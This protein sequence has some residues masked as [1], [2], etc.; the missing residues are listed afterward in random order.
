[1]NRPDAH[2]HLLLIL[3]KQQ[4]LQ[5]RHLYPWILSQ[6]C[7]MVMRWMTRCVREPCLALIRVE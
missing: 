7:V 2:V 1:M 6:N 3:V 4:R 5:R